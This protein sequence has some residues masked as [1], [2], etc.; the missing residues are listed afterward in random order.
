MK[1]ADGKTTRRVQEEI[2]SGW[3][4][5]EQM[6]GV[7][8]SLSNDANSEGRRGNWKHNSSN[9]KSRGVESLHSFDNSKGRG[10]LSIRN[11]GNNRGG[12]KDDKKMQ[13]QSS[14]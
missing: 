3:Q 5:E 7:C 10:G 4:R 12:W 9:N 1:E 11:F 13:D 2:C 8:N 14:E 6:S